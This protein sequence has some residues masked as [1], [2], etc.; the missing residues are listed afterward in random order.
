MD[1]GKVIA[2]GPTYEIFENP[3]K[4]Q[5]ARLT[6]CKNISKIEIIDDYHLKSI[7]WGVTFEVA[8]KISQEITHIGIRAHNFSAA[9]KDDINVMETINSTVLEMP[10]EWEVTLSNGL[11][12]KQD[13]RIRDHE[14]VLPEYL[15]VDSNDIILLKE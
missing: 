9:E 13:K 6:G 14:F 7:D 15:K 8:E 3:K 1:G 12:W 11:W 5:V 2:K 10:F 4:V